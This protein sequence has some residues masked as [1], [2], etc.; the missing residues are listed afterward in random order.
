MGELEGEGGKGGK[1]AW[2]GLCLFFQEISEPTFMGK[3]A[4]K[5]D[6]AGDLAM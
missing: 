4:R 6:V 1:G 3:K 2:A 5:G